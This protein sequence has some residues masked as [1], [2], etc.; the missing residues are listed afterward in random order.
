MKIFSIFTLWKI[1]WQYLKKINTKLPHD[2]ATPF[3]GIYQQKWKQRIKNICASMFIVALFTKSQ[4][5]KATQVIINR[6]IPKMWSISTVKYYSALKRKEN[7][8]YGW[9]KV[10]T[11]VQNMKPPRDGWWGLHNNID[12]LNLTEL[13]N[14]DGKFYVIYIRLSPQFITDAVAYSNKMKL[15]AKGSN[16]SKGNSNKNMY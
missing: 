11:S 7:L 6:C 3:Q 12:I 4:K 10:Q 15:Y 1:L 8:I 9:L 13:Y 5:V 16:E 14:Y 2:P